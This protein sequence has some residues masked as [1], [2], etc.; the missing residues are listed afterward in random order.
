MRQ[1][2]QIPINVRNFRSDCEDLARNFDLDFQA[3][4]E[5]SLEIF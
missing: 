1:A 3:I 2:P 5:D 4:Y